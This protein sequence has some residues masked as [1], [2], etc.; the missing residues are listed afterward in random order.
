MC[1]RGSGVSLDPRASVA[2]LS[3]ADQQMVEIARAMVHKVKL[4]VLDEPTAV[5]SGREVDAAVRS[6]CGGCATAA[7][8]SSSSP[9]VWRKSSQLCDRVTVLK[10]GELVGTSDVGGRQPRASDLDDGGTRSRRPVSAE[11]G[12]RAQARQP[13]LADRGRCRSPAGCATSRSS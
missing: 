3:V 5:I 4:L 2:S 13:A 7:S 12:G 1:W 10:D 9:I 11:T 6:R 8:P